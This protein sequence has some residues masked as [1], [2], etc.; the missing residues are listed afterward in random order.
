[1]AGP[2]AMGAN[3]ITGLANG[4]ASGDAAAFGQV[5]LCGAAATATGG[6]QAAGAAT[7]YTALATPAAVT[8]TTATKALVIV[9]A[10]LSNASTGASFLGFAVSGAT[11]LAASDAQAMLAQISGGN[12]QGSWVGLITLT[13]GVNTFELEYRVTSSTANILNAGI[14][15]VPF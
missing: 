1:M 13:A 9:S 15:V 2:I 8:V 6:A 14:T 10:E 3:K 7:S 5:P 4:S 12:G 11:T